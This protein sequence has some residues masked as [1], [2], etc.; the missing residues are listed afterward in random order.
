MLDDH[1]V[2]SDMVRSTFY[3]H[4]VST[5]ILIQVRRR[6]VNLCFCYAF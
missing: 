5:G 2:R 4:L 6:S 3:R 1:M